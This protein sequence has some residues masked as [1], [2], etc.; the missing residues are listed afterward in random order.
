M[1]NHLLRLALVVLVSGVTAPGLTAA[2]DESQC[3]PDP[4]TQDNGCVGCTTSITLQCDSLGGSC[5]GCEYTFTGVLNCPPTPLVWPG[6]G[7]LECG[8]K[9]TYRFGW[10]PSSGAPF[11]GWGE[12]QCQCE[13]CP[14]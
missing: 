6:I 8:D 12:L 7:D 3:E 1:R 9:I 2:W 10:C 11:G 4:H 14:Q 13:D 5:L